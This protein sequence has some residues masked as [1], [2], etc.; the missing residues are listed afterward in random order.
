MLEYRELAE[1][2]NAAH[3]FAVADL[4]GDG[5]PD[6]VTGIEFGLY[7][8]L[9]RGNGTF[10]VQPATW[11]TLLTGHMGDTPSPSRGHGVLGSQH[12]RCTR[13]GVA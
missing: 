9:N 12:E 1:G 7:V 6:M 11:V 10:I 5:V 4:V 2:N 13:T 8:L 3:C